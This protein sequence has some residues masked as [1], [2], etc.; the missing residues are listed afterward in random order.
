MQP[1]SPQRVNATTT[2]TTSTMQS[3]NRT[4]QPSSKELSAY[5]L[6]ELTM[7]I[8][9]NIPC[10]CVKSLTSHGCITE[11]NVGAWIKTLIR[12]RALQREAHYSEELRSLVKDWMPSMWI[13]IMQPRSDGD[14]SKVTY[15]CREIAHNKKDEDIFVVVSK[16]YSYYGK[17]ILEAAEKELEV[18]STE[19]KQQ[20]AKMRQ[21]WLQE[22]C[23]ALE[24]LIKCTCE[25]QLRTEAKKLLA[26]RRQQKNRHLSASP[27]PSPIKKLFG[28]KTAAIQI[29]D[30]IMH[31][32]ADNKLV[33]ARVFFNKSIIESVVKEVKLVFDRISSRLSSCGKDNDIFVYAKQELDK[34][35]KSI[36]RVLKELDVMKSQ[37]SCFVDGASEATQENEG[38]NKEL[39]EQKRLIEC[40]QNQLESLT[41]AHGFL[42]RQ[43][44]EKMDALNELLNKSANTG[45]DLPELKDLLSKFETCFSEVF[46]ETAIAAVATS[47]TATAEP[48]ATSDGLDQK[49]AEAKETLRTLAQRRID[50]LVAKCQTIAAVDAARELLPKFEEVFNKKFDVAGSDFA[51]EAAALVGFAK[52]LDEIRE[53]IAKYDG[54]L[55]NLEAEK[56]E[57]TKNISE[58]LTAVQT[59][60]KELAQCRIEY[61]KSQSQKIRT[62]ATAKLISVLNSEPLQKENIGS[63]FAEQKTQLHLLAEF[64]DSTAFLDKCNESQESD[65]TGKLKQEMIRLENIANEVE[66]K[67]VELFVILS[68]AEAKKAKF[69]E[70]MLAS[71][72]L[73]YLHE[74][75]REL[76]KAN[77]LLQEIISKKAELEVDPQFIEQI[78]SRKNALDKY[79]ADLI[80]RFETEQE[81]AAKIVEFAEKIKKFGASI[82]AFTIELTKEQL[83]KLIAES[84]SIQKELGQLEEQAE[85]T[86]KV[87]KE[88]IIPL[89]SAVVDVQQKIDRLYRFRGVS[90]EIAVL[91]RAVELIARRQA[92]ESLMVDSLTETVGKLRELEK[93][94]A[95]FVGEE[96]LTPQPSPKKGVNGSASNS[97]LSQQGSPRKLA[98]ANGATSGNSADPEQSPKNGGSDDWYQS[99]L[100]LVTILTQLQECARGNGVRDLPQ[101]T[102]GIYSKD[103]I[104]G[105]LISDFQR[106]LLMSIEKISEAMEAITTKTLIAHKLEEIPTNIKMLQQAITNLPQ[107]KKGSSVLEEIAS[108]EKLQSAITAIKKDFDS[109]QYVAVRHGVSMQTSLTLE[110]T[111]LDSKLDKLNAVIV[112]SK[113]KEYYGLQISALKMKIEILLGKKEGI[114]AS[115]QNNAPKV[116]KVDDIISIIV[117]FDKLKRDVANTGLSVKEDFNEE[118]RILHEKLQFL[119]KATKNAIE[120]KMLNCRQLAGALEESTRIYEHLTQLPEISEEDGKYKILLQNSLKELE[121][122]ITEIA[123]SVTQIQISTI[124]NAMVYVGKLIENLERADNAL[125]KDKID[126]LKWQLSA[127]QKEV[128]G[129]TSIDKRGEIEEYKNTILKQLDSLLTRQAALVQKCEQ[130]KQDKTC[131]ETLMSSLN[132]HFQSSS[133][134]YGSERDVGNMGKQLRDLILLK[135]RTCELDCLENYKAFKYLQYVG[136]ILQLISLLD[137]K[138]TG[139]TGIHSK[140]IDKDDF[141][142]I[143]ICEHMLK[144]IFSIIEGS[145]ECVALEV[146]SAN[147]VSL[148]TFKEYMT[149]LQANRKKPSWGRDSFF[150]SKQDDKDIFVDLMISIFQE[151]ESSRDE[152]SK[153]IDLMLETLEMRAIIIRNCSPSEEEKKEERMR[154]LAIQ[155]LY[156]SNNFAAADDCD[157]GKS[158]LYALYD[159]YFSVSSSTS[160]DVSEELLVVSATDIEMLTEIADKDKTRI[161]WQDRSKKLQLLSSYSKEACEN[162]RTRKSASGIYFT[163]L[164]VFV[165]NHR[166]QEDNLATVAAATSTTTAT[167]TTTTMA[168]GTF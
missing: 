100:S 129:I 72:I 24:L 124:N 89:R 33:C 71:Q 143:K 85:T 4:I 58:K 109:L 52:R 17:F 47:A 161:N 166:Q 132:Q 50:E 122:K 149:L 29:N 42:E 48:A 136:L 148:G 14:Y 39:A 140:D 156:V 134:V 51:T 77:A 99:A 55:G 94:R 107:E 133:L 139:Q 38:L 43:K 74:M 150:G 81:S 144:F 95:T 9:K 142:K 120:E 5:S 63:F 137:V 45:C 2:A 167:A 116:L 60:L 10:A 115:E 97:S 168:A 160:S 46:P 75:K 80:P 152:K 35:V 23:F 25:E 53:Q 108:R 117:P 153:F 87:N 162:V 93:R 7:E 65:A 78:A 12:Y 151:A 54:T 159:K 41:H 101:L 146:R 62:D 90:Q 3:P 135:L 82:P 164:S 27:K 44:V 121:S 98:G 112:E 11:G 147:S 113:F 92:A 141:E 157:T 8:Q 96:R 114:S 106:T 103:K 20:A 105:S 21:E 13:S 104:K 1:Q 158:I 31:T 88:K 40:L 111:S 59:K 155:S 49:I 126:E 119:E 86:R 145:S 19:E 56:T 110:L 83:D 22:T 34:A 67:I 18:S 16:F 76:E 32:S 123:K 26:A 6:E 68:D 125:S 73:S 138:Q 127:L 66:P 165:K 69:S 37:I 118:V 91:T 130:Q 79:I 84:E 61:V 102:E 131:K 28:A 30:D 70:A 163:A 128:A 36:P 154:T 57:S 64:V 15:Y